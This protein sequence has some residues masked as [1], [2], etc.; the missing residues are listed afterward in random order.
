M[1][2]HLSWSIIKDHGRLLGLYFVFLVSSLFESK[3]KVLQIKWPHPV[4]SYI[5]LYSPKSPQAFTELQAIYTYV[6]E[7]F[8]FPFKC[9]FVDTY[10]VAR[11]AHKVNLAPKM[12]Y[13]KHTPHDWVHIRG[14]RMFMW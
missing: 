12:V 10:C 13:G 2:E 5:P 9:D 7:A 4:H 6:L 1:F 3:P 8:P 11:R 14:E